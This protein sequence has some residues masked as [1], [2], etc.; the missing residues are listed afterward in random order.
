MRSILAPQRAPT[1]TGGTQ[2]NGDYEINLDGQQVTQLLSVAAGAGPP[3]F[4]RDAIGEVEL[5]SGRFDA[6]QGRAL[7]I[8]VNVATKSGANSFM[9]STAGYFRDDSWNAAD[10]VVGRVLPYEDQ[11]WVGTFG[12]PIPP[13]PDALLRV[14][15][16]RAQPDDGCLF[17]ALPAFQWRSVQH[18]HDAICSRRAW[19][20]SSRA[21]RVSRCAA[22][23][24]IT[25]RPNL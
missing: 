10:P 9:G 17:D 16:R 13:Q 4:S 24:T 7:G 2:G 14:V 3:R 23:P 22:R 15:R 6:T 21:V 25:R 11:Q 18:Q 1:T 5:K 20:P 12:G 8:Q 19:T